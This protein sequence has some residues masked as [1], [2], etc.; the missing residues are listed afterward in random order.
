MGRQ[1]DSYFKAAV[2]IRAM[3]ESNVLGLSQVS[4]EGCS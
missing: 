2:C 3:R 4:P 1:I